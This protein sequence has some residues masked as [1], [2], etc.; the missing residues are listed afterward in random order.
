MNN[1][2]L[3]ISAAMPLP[4][5]DDPNRPRGLYLGAQYSDDDLLRATFIV[6]GE[7]LADGKDLPAPVVAIKVVNQVFFWSPAETRLARPIL[8]TGLVNVV[9]PE[10]SNTPVAQ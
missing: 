3:R 8:S 9:L 5:D 7:V 6:P 10:D 4:P 1:D 2:K